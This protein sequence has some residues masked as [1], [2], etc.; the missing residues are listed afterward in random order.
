V[1][2]QRSAHRGR[3][4]LNKLRSAALL[5]SVVGCLAVVLAACGSSSSSSSSS[6]GA[7]A[8]TTSGSG[9]GGSS[10]TSASSSASSLLPSPSEYGTPAQVQQLL[11]ASFGPGVKINQLQPIAQQAYKIFAKP[12]TPAESA[13]VARCLKT[14]GACSVGHPN[15]T[16]N[17]AESEDTNNDYYKTVR[18]MYILMAIR[19][20][21]V[22]TISY[23]NAN[24]VVPQALSNF[25]THISQGANIIVGAFDL[26]NV[27]LPVV[28]EAAAQHITVWTATQTI[29]DAK[30]D[31]S[32]LGGDVLTNLCTYGKTM[33]DLAL[34]SGKTVAMYTGSAGN[35]FAAQWQPCAKKEIAAKGGDLVEDGNTNWT[36]QGEQ[37][38]AAALAAKG[39]PDSLI[40]DY[41]PAAF[42][43]KFLQLGKTP[44]TMVGGSQ[45]MAAYA[46]W[47]Q[48]QAKGINFKSYIAGSEQTFAIVSLNAAIAQHLGQSVPHHILLPQPVV[49][50]GDYTKYYSSKFPSGANF[51]SG[52]PNPLILL[53]FSDA[54]S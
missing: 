48:A 1:G 28:R 3:G 41:T 33:A 15:G 4:G 26:G 23:T 20:P 5:L 53:G 47:K 54:T 39:L 51:G 6:S 30:F 29:P 32:D 12:V 37:Q 38:A 7:G 8:S 52:L 49:P 46:A 35:S 22:K 25:R 31:G 18:A 42:M 17:V 27:M 34:Q 50:A 24:F 43:T 21:A 13:I 16:L 36:V 44:P 14:T 2:N 45:T 11:D 19:E 9:S 40:Y 10:S